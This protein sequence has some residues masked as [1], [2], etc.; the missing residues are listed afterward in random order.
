MPI[1]VQLPS[2]ETAEFPDGMAPAHIQAEIESHPTAA[3]SGPLGVPGFPTAPNPQITGPLD[4][5]LA[6]NPGPG[7][8]GGFAEHLRP[9]GNAGRRLARNVQ[10]VV[11]HPSSLLPDP[12][13][14]MFPIN[15]GGHLDPTVPHGGLPEQ[16]LSYGRTAR[17]QGFTQAASD[18]AGD[19]ATAYL[20]GK[21]LGAAPE[22]AARTLNATGRGLKSAGALSSRIGIGA[23]S[24]SANLGADAGAGLSETRT[25]GATPRSLSTRLAPKIEAASQ[26]RDSILSR[27][28]APPTDVSAAVS[29]PFDDIAAIKAHPR[30]GA[31]RS[32]SLS[33]MSGVK[34][35]IQEVQDPDTGFPTGTP[36]DPNLSPLEMSQLGRNVYA[37]TDYANPEAD[38]ANQG[39]KGVGANLRDKI[40]TAAPESATM[41]DQLHNMLGAEEVVKGKIGSGAIPDTKTGLIMGAV[42]GA[43]TLAGTAVGAGLDAAGSGMMKMGGAIRSFG[44]PVAPQT[45]PATGPTP[46]PVQLPA[47]TPTYTPNSPAPAGYLP[48]PYTPPRSSSPVTTPPPVTPRGLL[49]EQAGPTHELL[50]HGGDFA[51]ENLDRPL[52]TGSKSL[53]SQYAGRPDAKLQP[54]LGRVGSKAPSS[55]ISEAARNADLDNNYQK[56]WGIDGGLESDPQAHMFD[57]GQVGSP[58]SV[59]RRS[60]MESGYDHAILPETGL[61][62]GQDSTILLDPANQARELPPV[63]NLHPGRPNPGTART[64]IQ[65]TQTRPT[66]QQVLQDQP[67]Y[68]PPKGG[69][70]LLSTPEGIRPEPYPLP[71][72]HQVPALESRTGPRAP[73]ARP[74]VL[75][76]MKG[77]M[78]AAALE[79]NTPRYSPPPQ[80]E[81]DLP[82]SYRNLRSKLKSA[83]SGPS[84]PMSA[85]LSDQITE[86]KQATK[87]RDQM[88]SENSGKPGMWFDEDKQEWSPKQDIPGDW[89]LDDQSYNDIPRLKDKPTTSTINGVPEE[90]YYAKRN[91]TWSKVTAM[92][93][94]DVKMMAK[95]DGYTGDRPR[96]HISQLDPDAMAAVYKKFHGTPK[97]KLLSKATSTRLPAP[98]DTD[99]WEALVDEGKARY[100]V[101]THQYDYLD[102]AP[103]VASRSQLN[104]DPSRV[105]EGDHSSLGE[106][107]YHG[108][109]A[110]LMDSIRNKGLQP[111]PNI[112]G[113]DSGVYLTPNKDWAEVHANVM[114]TGM[115][116]W[117][118]DMGIELPVEH[119]SKPAI[120]TVNI[121]RKTLLHKD[122]ASS[123]DSPDFIG[124]GS[125]YTRKS[126][127]KQSVI[128]T[129]EMG[130]SPIKSLQNKMWPK[131]PRGKK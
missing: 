93:D 59:L 65:P 115:D 99:G 74:K 112:Q 29:R 19:A 16:V 118:P 15:R 61:G 120:A 68:T 63:G 117:D 67:G 76:Q 131:K 17:D 86:Q 105:E 30:T 60:L 82:P 69:R 26:A 71:A 129:K 103:A 37:M 24:A 75:S 73:S 3:G 10:G 88:Q 119:Q 116:P 6:N 36:K 102:K 43:K 54:L 1:R 5:A 52:F 123:G 11:E 39:L 78:E 121:P 20:T 31:A 50:Y 9:V 46:P 8:P 13:S 64:R 101:Q 14:V 106:T 28:A 125:V 4:T 130:I 91:A 122:F 62:S 40:R 113:E 128:D 44:S 21:A 96:A 66:S 35:A 38:L 80:I 104:I 56:M 90:E 111:G 127:P 25:V 97:P 51:G 126:L 27:S 114:A 72:P 77:D 48:G 87:L 55:A 45:P 22:A 53:A 95:S 12:A 7:K 89:K 94:A 18:V 34:R 84:A 70:R 124:N 108:T 98:T 41:T 42:K 23:P 110:D 100:N 33:Q 58:A 85:K 81:S 83:L 109:R 57:E 32:R 107:L 92:S 2:G 79:A 47:N 49:S